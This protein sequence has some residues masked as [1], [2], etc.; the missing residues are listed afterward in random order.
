MGVAAR[1]SDGRMG[2]LIRPSDGYIV[3]IKRPSGGPIT[4]ERR[5]SELAGTEGGS[6]YQILLLS[7]GENIICIHTSMGYKNTRTQ[8]HICIG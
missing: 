3:T 4:V 8:K 7:S 6:D 1:P 2:Y 5:W